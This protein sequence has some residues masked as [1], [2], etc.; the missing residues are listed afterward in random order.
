MD[1]LN[2][3]R[4]DIPKIVLFTAFML[5]GSLFDIYD[6]IFDLDFK[7]IWLNAHLFIKDLFALGSVLLSYHLCGF[8]RLKLKT[9][10]FLMCVWRLFI[11]LF[12]P[13]EIYN[14]YFILIPYA[15]Y[16]VLLLRIFLFNAELITYTNSNV[17]KNIITYNIFIPVHSF[18]GLI[19]ALLLF[20]RDPRYETTILVNSDKMYY[21]KNKHFHTENKS[22]EIIERLI[23]KTHAKINVK[24]LA[25]KKK[26]KI[27]KLLY[28]R[29]I[30]GFKDCSKLK[31]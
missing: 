8:E 16:T 4:K 9:F 31:I 21:V 26:Q 23:N 2:R 25:P 20:W 18:R 27:N 17:L 1:K 13:L 15:I 30:T 14:I 19:Q 24:Y 6:L 5:V 10:L 29:A 22:V 11:L 12:N 3:K 7:T 28:K